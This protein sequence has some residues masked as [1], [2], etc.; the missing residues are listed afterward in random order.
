[1]ICVLSGCSNRTL[2]NDMYSYTQSG[3]DKEVRTAF[4]ILSNIELNDTLVDIMKKDYEKENDTAKKFLYEY[5]FAKRIQETP[6]ISSFVK[7]SRANFPILL[8]NS[9]H[10][11]SIGSP[12]LE[13]LSIYSTTND[14]ALGTLLLLSIDADGTNLSIITSSLRGIYKRQPNRLMV[15]ANKMELDINNILLLMENG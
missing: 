3:T 5:L 12:I 14:D 11:V 1:M 4:I 9:S 8:D 15:M 6:Y 10:W 2:I 13:L 7:N